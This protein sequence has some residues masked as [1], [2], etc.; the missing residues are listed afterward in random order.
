[1]FFRRDKISYYL[2][3]ILIMIEIIIV[4]ILG[5]KR[6][7]NISFQNEPFYNLNDN[8]TYIDEN[9]KEQIISLPVKIDAGLDNTI[10]IYRKLPSGMYH[11]RALSIMT[12]HQDIV[13]YIG[14]RL[15]YSR[16]KKA[17]YNFFDVPTNNIM[18]IV[19][20]PPGSEGKQITITISSKYKEYAGLIDEIHAGSKSALL[21]RAI[22]LFGL[23]LFLAMITFFLGI[24]IIMIYIF[25]K[26]LLKTNRSILFLGWFSVLCSIWLIMESNLTQMFIENEYII[27]SLSY[28]SLMTFPIPILI[29]ITFI[30]NFHYKKVLYS[31]IY[32]L[33]ASDFILILLQFLNIYDLHQSTSVVRF[34]IYSLLGFALTT[35]L[36]EFFYHKNKA[37]KVFT[38]SST[39][40]FLFGVAEFLVINRSYS[41]SGILFQ[42]GFIIFIT[43]LS[44]DA[45]RKVA[46]V[47][48]LSETAQHYKFLAT[49]DL[50]TSCRNRVSY[51]KDMDR[52]SLERNITMFVADMNNMKQINDTYGHHAGDEAII[53]CSQCLLKV[54]GRRVY[55]IGGDEFV[56]IQYDLAPTQIELM[57]ADFQKE[58]LKAN[59][60]TAYKFF[61]SIGY[62]VFDKKI[63]QTIYDTVDRADKDMYERKNKMK[64]E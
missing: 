43:I 8:W 19:E 48:K 28:L 46:D 59:E 61:M 33:L 56:I 10:S 16:M 39:T 21:L 18:D 38:I 9:D 41:N 44:W 26:H 35:L 42:V 11:M 12:S 5:F 62:A 45:L 58:C 31:L 53:L 27:S 6:H 64:I 30:D 40:L 52:V 60:D 25:I 63:D 51:A 24:V 32:I 37:I 29:Y 57:L 54:F 17:S 47:I 13:V 22:K 7:T 20:L 49:K 3:Y 50:L 1:M 55:R 2:F 36:L 14:T 23:R 34:E 15:V 4:A